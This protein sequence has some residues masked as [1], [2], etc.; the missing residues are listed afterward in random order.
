MSDICCRTKCSKSIPCTPMYRSPSMDIP[1]AQYSK[2]VCS[3]PIPLPVP[4]VLNIS[5]NS[6]TALTAPTAPQP[7]FVRFFLF[8]PNSVRAIYRHTYYSHFYSYLLFHSEASRPSFLLY[9]FGI[10][11]ERRRL[12]LCKDKAYSRKNRRLTLGVV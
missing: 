1:R 5:P 3:I 9:L 2:Y 12:S 8:W 11:H 6:E 4:L 10:R 7:C